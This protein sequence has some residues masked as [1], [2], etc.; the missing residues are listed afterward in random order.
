MAAADVRQPVRDIREEVVALLTE[1]F[2]PAKSLPEQWDLEGLAGA[3]EREFGLRVD[4][5]SGADSYNDEGDVRKRI[6][7]AIEQE[8]ERKA[9]NVG[10]PVMRAIEKQIMLQQL[11]QHW[12]EHLAALDYLRQGIGWRSLAGRKPEQE[13]KREAFD[14]FSNMLDRIKGDTISLL[15]RIQVRSQAEI[16]REEEERH[17]RLARAMQLQHAEAPSAV[18][19]PPQLEDEAEAGR[20]AQLAA[21]PFVRSDR[22]VGRNEPCPCGSGR[23]F[24]HCHGALA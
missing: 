24:K 4:L 11:D 13:Y 16:E 2:V 15:S 19:P 17:R 10:E 7:A 9:A 14:L 1:R 20:G 5:K 3:V 12:R 22:K 23:K 18:A 6:V 8:Y 21:A